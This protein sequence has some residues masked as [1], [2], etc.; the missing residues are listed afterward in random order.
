MPSAGRRPSV[1]F[2]PVRPQKPA[3]RRTEPPVSVPTAQTAIPAATAAAEPDDEPPQTRCVAMSH[4][5]RGVPM[6]W[7][8]PQPPKASSTVLVLP[9]R[10]PPAASRRRATVP[11]AGETR[12]SSA[13]E[14]P[15][16]I[17]PSTSTMSLRANGIP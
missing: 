15:V 3:G 17:R 12:S 6:R 4:G 1:T 2:R 8:V 11:V 10:M 14:P 7:F 13:F 9:S 16:V 5:L